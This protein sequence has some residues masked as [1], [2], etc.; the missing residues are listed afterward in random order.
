MTSM[1][2]GD[3]M[4][5]NVTTGGTIGEGGRPDAADPFAALLAAAERNGAPPALGAVR[6]RAAATYR[7]RGLPTR[8]DESWRYTDL[9]RLR[10][11]DLRRATGADVTAP[12]AGQAL[13]RLPKLCAATAAR[14]VFVNGGYRADLS[15]LAAVPAGV[16]VRP[17]AEA[18]AD[19]PANVVGALEADHGAAAAELP[20]IA[21]NTAL[22]ADGTLIEVADGCGAAGD[23]AAIELV[24]IGDGTAVASALRHVVRVGTGGRLAI[25]E[26]HLA[27]GGE[28]G[29]ANGVMQ[30]ALAEGATLR[31]IRVIEGGGALMSVLTTQVDVAGDAAYESFALT[32][33]GGFSR[34]ETSVRLNAPRAACRIAGAYAIG[35]RDLCDNT[36]NVW[37][38]CPK[39]TSRQ[40]FKGVIDGAAHAVFQGRIVVERGAEEADGHQLSKALLLSDEAEIDQKPALEIFAD[41]VKCSHGAAAGQL[42]ATAMF[43]LRSRGLPEALARRMLLEG[44]LADVLLELS[45]EAARQTLAERIAAAVQGLGKDH[46]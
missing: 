43:Y 38:R 36:V 15:S 5:G 4:T 26:H 34:N 42:D 10:Q 41:N 30:V 24:S 9:K 35:G 28:D 19:D 2:T 31:H 18:I 11:I 3:G 13:A 46:A 16:R 33:G 12:R 23:E 44:F 40:V 29:F 6:R 7:A 27:D 14:L 45:D 37:H 8:R 20:L 1:A 32:L 25:I 21:L 39:T 22:F 17:L